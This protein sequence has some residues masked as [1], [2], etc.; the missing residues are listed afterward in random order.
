V[1]E[2]TLQVSNQIGNNDQKDES[3]QEKQQGSSSLLEDN[4]VMVT[5]PQD[6]LDVQSKASTNALLDGELGY[7]LEVEQMNN[8]LVDVNERQFHRVGVDQNVV[9]MLGIG[10]MGLAGGIFFYTKKRVAAITEEA[11]KR[12]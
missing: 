2:S 11:K 12:V 3:L 6:N 5:E 4:K 1:I 8:Q 9:G 10:I 7:E